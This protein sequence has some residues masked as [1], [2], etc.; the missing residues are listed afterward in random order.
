MSGDTTWLVVPGTVVGEQVTTRRTREQGTVI[1][2]TGEPVHPT[3][4]FAVPLDFAAAWRAGR[5]RR[6]EAVRP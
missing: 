1:A 5:A 4:V 6:P 3:I 2:A